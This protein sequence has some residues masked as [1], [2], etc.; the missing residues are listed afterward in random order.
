VA[1]AAMPLAPPE[2][3]GLTNWQIN[4]IAKAADAEGE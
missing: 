4:E 2:L 3:N 1:G